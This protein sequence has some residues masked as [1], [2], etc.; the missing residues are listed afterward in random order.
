MSLTLL[1]A[2][3]IA[4]LDSQNRCY[5]P[6]YLVVENDRVSEVGPQSALVGR[7]FDHEIDLAGRLIMPGLVNAHTHTPMV[8]FRGLAAAGGHLDNT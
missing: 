5:Q 2:D 8:L 6:G 7:R 3:I 4:T 1:R